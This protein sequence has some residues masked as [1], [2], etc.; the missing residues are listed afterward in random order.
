L[1]SGGEILEESADTFLVFEE[2]L[3]T[4]STY[5]DQMDAL[6]K[7]KEDARS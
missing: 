3:A 4:F 2:E 1:I 7:I 5:K 6:D